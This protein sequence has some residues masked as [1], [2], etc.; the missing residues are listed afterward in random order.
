M[1][2]RD[3]EQNNEYQMTKTPKQTWAVRLL[4]GIGFLLV[5][6]VL[7]M[8]FFPWDLLRQPVNRYVSDATGRK[9]E[10]TRRLDVDLGWRS[11]TVKLDGVEFANPSWARDPYLIRT[12]RAE[13]D[14]R[15]WPLWSRK[16]VIPRL[17]LASPSL[18]LQME[19]DGRR[20][21]A[22]GKDTS[23]SGT[24]PEIGLLQVDGGTLDF[25]A[26]HLG[27]DLHADFNFDTDKGDMPLSYRIKGRY[28]EQPLTA[29]GRTGNVMQLTA[30]G[31]SPFP[32]EI[33][34][35]AGQT[36]LKASGTIVS[37]AELDGVNAKFDL[38]GQS[39]GDLYRLLGVALP[40]SSPYAISGDLTKQAKLWAVQGL[41]GKLGLSDIAGDMQFDQAQTPAQLGGVLRSRVL[42]MDDLGPLIGLPPTERSANAVQGVAP[43]ASVEQVQRAKGNGKV[44]PSAI[45]DF[46][47][48]RAMNADVKYTADRIKNVR[49]VPLDNGSVQVKL[50]DGVLT[51]DPLSLGVA[52]GKLAGAVR[53]DASQ[54]PAD[55]RMSLDVRRM[56]LN[57]LIPKVETL[58]TSFS[59]LD[60]RVNLSGRGNSVA[61]WLGGASGDVAAITGHGEFSNL[62][63]EFMGLDGGEI[64]KF[65]LRGDHN[66]T[67]RCAAAAFDVNK[68]VMTSRDLVFDTTDTVFHGSGQA[69]FA[70][71]TLD[72]VINQ[73]PKDM[74]ILS[75]R[76]PLLVRGTFGSPSAGVEKG[77]LIT[78]GLAAL[79]L[80]AINPLLA[81]AA[82]VE[83]GPGVDADCAEV[84]TRS[85]QPVSSEASAGAK[86]GKTAKQP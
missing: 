51:L 36:R 7:I 13:F 28:H 14:I 71:E 3:V 43:P 58:R 21:W 53:I 40:Q 60:G 20:T 11:A 63:L 37:L 61:S 79:A 24:V 4:I 22:L 50:H 72:F 78:R 33:D 77:P 56:Q 68:G 49:D 59:S 29:Q 70:N 55:I 8:L 32:I 48:L 41:K 25:F 23:D 34:A 65:L 10:I 44:L 74:S 2:R 84:L 45:L 75:L 69:N 76:T 73:E 86:K 1:P 6:M 5:V 66:V 27:V 54:N 64:I 82:T 47:R 52:G 12:E 83:T 30:A 80:G 9:F 62:L 85:K 35:A 17:S 31:Q 38:S 26:K 67:M 19:S 57:R 81:L 42:D 15:L 18:G 16:V 46:E 39:L